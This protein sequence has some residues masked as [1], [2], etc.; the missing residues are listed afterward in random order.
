MRVNGKK[1][2][3][4]FLTYQDL[5]KGGRIQFDMAAQPNYH[6]GIN[7]DDRPYSY[8]SNSN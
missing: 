1:Y 4:N 2:S 5:I 3:R 7:K 8:S 6:R